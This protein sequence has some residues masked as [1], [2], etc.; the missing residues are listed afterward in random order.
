MSPV[1]RG[2]GAYGAGK[3]FSQ[4]EN[5][6][7]GSRV[8]QAALVAYRAFSDVAGKGAFFLVTVMAA[9]ALTRDAFGVFALGTTIGWMAAVISDFGMQMHLARAVARAPDQAATLLRTWLNARLASAAM[10]LVMVAAVV[11]L[12]PA[13]YATALVALTF[14]YLVSGVIEFLHYFY[15]GL[16]RTEIES[17]LTLVHRM[18][19]L[20]CAGAA[21][22]WRRDVTTL[23]L[24]MAVP[25][26]LTA[27]YSLRR[28]RR[29]ADEVSSARDGR[30]RS[31]P[32]LPALPALR[33]AWPIGAG[34]VLSALY[35]RV[36][37]FLL[38]RWSG[39]GAVALYN[40]VFRLVEA[41]RLFPAAVLAVALPWLCRAVT[42]KPV[43][44]VSGLLVGF[45]LVVTPVLWV[46]AAWL[47]PALYG[48][49]FAEA[50]DAFRILLIAFPLMSL[51]YALTHQLI[52]W[53]GHRSYAAL[54]A[55]ALVFNVAI[56]ARLIPSLSIL[57]AAWATV[58]TEALLTLGCV[59]ALWLRAARPPAVAAAVAP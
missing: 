26:V 44:Q 1:G 3:L 25:V 55:A 45:S 35:F 18:G 50:V 31:A 39:T 17:T 10:M 36:D 4:R 8:Q 47:V 21:L 41:L 19:T 56:N 48:S 54:C 2:P 30:R 22:A 43:A 29:M 9:R 7:K 13:S 28:A 32:A 46:S 14:V 27:A 23:A 34:I 12:L 38:E 49:G 33:E 42:V 57:G 24:G 51:N 20:A 53:D 40:A 59:G 58:G 16:S 6:A 11:W 52:G 37:I 15:R 5:A